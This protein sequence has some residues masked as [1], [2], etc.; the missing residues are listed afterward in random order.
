MDALL[1][2]GILT[3]FAAVMIGVGVICTINALEAYRYRAAYGVR[4]SL[5]W[6]FVLTAGAVTMF[7]LAAHC[8]TTILSC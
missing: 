2:A 7:A 1:C 3:G 8:L 5:V 6:C 4:D